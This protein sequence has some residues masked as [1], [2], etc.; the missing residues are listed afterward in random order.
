MARP[1]NLPFAV[2]SARPADLEAGYEGFLEGKFPTESEALS[3]VSEWNRLHAL[4]G[5][6]V[7]FYLG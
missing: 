6:E 4:Y 7:E 1:A 2:Y 5:N 3:F